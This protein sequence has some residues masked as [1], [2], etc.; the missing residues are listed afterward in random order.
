MK[1]ANFLSQKSIWII[2]LS[3]LMV[4]CLTFPLLAVEMSYEEY[5]SVERSLEQDDSFDGSN[6]M[7]EGPLLMEES[8]LSAYQEK[9][10]DVQISA[11]NVYQLRNVNGTPTLVCI[12]EGDYSCCSYDGNY[13]YLSSGGTVTRWNLLTLESEVLYS[14]EMP[15]DMLWGTEEI[16]FFQS[17]DQIYHYYVPSRTLKLSLTAK[18]LDAWKV[19]SNRVIFVLETN[20]DYWEAV[21]A[22]GVG[23][24]EQPSDPEAFSAWMNEKFDLH[25][26][27]E[28]KVFQQCDVE[29]ILMVC[30]INHT[31]NY[32]YDIIAKKKLSEY[33][34]E[35]DPM[36]TSTSSGIQNNSEIEEPTTDDSVTGVPATDL[37]AET[38]SDSSA[39]PAEKQNGAVTWLL[40]GLGVGVIAV[41]LPVVILLRGKKRKT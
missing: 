40:V 9:Y 17:G 21:E 10:P 22:S 33:T 8:F 36:Q 4:V 13:M 15:I 25:T 2:L 23:I 34:V 37:P 41:A 31:N 19:L 32:W 1:Y 35:E 18:D 11:G 24:W 26:S 38:A 5:M 16:V 39:A 3:V 20:P 27:P 7:L 29:N 12:A 30:G 6:G 28:S 14:G